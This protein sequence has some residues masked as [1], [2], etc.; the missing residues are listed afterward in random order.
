MN[1]SLLKHQAKKD[2]V[3]IRRKNIDPNTIQAFILEVSRNLVLLQYVYDFNLDGLMVLRVSDISQ[4]RCSQ[5]EQF[6]RELLKDEKLF[7]KVDFSISIDL[8][9]WKAAIS[10]LR[11]HYEY[12]IFENESPNDSMFLIGKIHKMTSRS[13][14]VNHFSGTGQWE[15]HSTVMKFHDITA[16]RVNTNYIN[17]YQR[18]FEKNLS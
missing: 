9:D 15:K 1:D 10:C 17:V 7:E 11:S 12:F 13:I 4:V 5:T 3:D 2:L 14:H 8:T 16:C 6:Q 18:Y